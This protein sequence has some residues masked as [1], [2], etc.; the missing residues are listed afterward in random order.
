VVDPID[1][2]RPP[3]GGFVEGSQ[4]Q[5]PNEDPRHPSCRQTRE[6]V[7]SHAVIRLI[8]LA[9]DVHGRIVDISL[10]GCRIQ[11][12]RLF[13]VGVFRRVEVEFRIAGL[14]Y[15]FGGVIQAIYD[16]FN[17]GIRFLDLSER[18]REQLMQLI[19]EISERPPTPDQN[20]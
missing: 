8:N 19:D 9:S 10:G 12:D 14:P 15:R 2:E 18:K 5:K 1:S 16:S 20:G 4:P 13:P 6:V 3:G 7:D 11:T 17:V